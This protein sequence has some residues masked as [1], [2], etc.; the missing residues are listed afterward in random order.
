[1]KRAREGGG[2]WKICSGG[3]EVHKADEL[4]KGTGAGEGG[5]CLRVQTGTYQDRVIGRPDGLAFGQTRWWA[6]I[7]KR[8]CKS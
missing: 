5:Q 6:F 8:I 1:M 4:E 7:F 3:Q 2:L